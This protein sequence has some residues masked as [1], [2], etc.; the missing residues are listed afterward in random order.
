[1]YK[2]RRI[3]DSI[4]AEE[5]DQFLE[6]GWFRM[7]QH[8]FTTEFLQMGIDFYDAIW[9]RNKLTGFRFP[10]WFGKMKR[11][12]RFRAEVTAFHPG[13][14]NEMLYQSYRESKPEGFPESLESILYGE[15][16][17]NIFNT[18]QVNI[19]EGDELVGASFF[20]VGSNSAMGIVS[21]YEP[22]YKSLGMGKYATMLAYE[23]CAVNGLTWFY[24]GYFAPGNPSFDYKVRF[25]PG[26]LEYL[27]MRQQEWMP[28]SAFR[29][30]KLPKSAISQELAA[31]EATLDK[32][33]LV[34]CIIHNIFFA[35]TEN[36]R[37]DCPL[38][39]LVCVPG[40][41]SSQALVTYDHHTGEFHLFRC[42][43]TDLASE[44]K[45]Y[46]HKM[47]C[48]QHFPLRKPDQSFPIVREAAHSIAA[49]MKT[50]S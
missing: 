35:F 17:T 36:S 21:Y 33:G 50:S 5:L 8:M 31:L 39:L 2:A 44:T 15:G 19:Y 37:Y 41:L 26:S 3:M 13:P 45:S 34:S 30:D 25:D 32:E 28:M 49:L 47:I 24:P 23:Y 29:P 12:M 14:E 43:D 16:D 40:D 22:R 27:N 7:K 6:K 4:A 10:K 18:R 42:R 20:D 1:M 48:M 9:L 38:M 46:E 11:N